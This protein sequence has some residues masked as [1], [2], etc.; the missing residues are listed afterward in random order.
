MEML[1]SFEARVIHG[2][3]RGK[4]M[5]TPTINVELSDVPALQHGVYAGAV[6][7]NNAT[8][9][10]AIH[11]GLRPTFND[12]E[13]FEVHVIDQDITDVPEKITIHVLGYIRKIESFA[14]TEALVKEIEKDISISRS[15]FNKH[16]V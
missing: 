15:I 10:A 13:T 8:Y 5:K 16:Y 11:Y 2:S 3:G 6:M 7:L 12:S 14:S 1:A 4:G 9:P